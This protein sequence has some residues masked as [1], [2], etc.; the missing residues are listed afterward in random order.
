MYYSVAI[1]VVTPIMTQRTVRP[2][3]ILIFGGGNM[4]ISLLSLLMPA[5]CSQ[6]DRRDNSLIFTSANIG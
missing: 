5:I 3:V 4:K 2:A 1:Q 6:E